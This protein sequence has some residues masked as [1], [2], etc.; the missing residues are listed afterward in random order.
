M[1]ATDVGTLFLD[2]QLRIKRFTPKVSELFNIQAP[3]EGRP[4]TD[5]THRLDYP[6]FAAD[7][8][9]VLKDLK[10]IER[11]IESNGSWFLTRIRPY[12]TVDDRIEGVVCTFVDITARL[13][14]EADL[15]ASEA[16]L[17]LLLSE[18][19][20]RVKNTLAVVQAMARLSFAE[21]VPRDQARGGVHEQA[22]RTFRRP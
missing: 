7:A 17:R 10:I 9:A 14:M 6:N 21:D 19:S 20:H 5:F 13:K 1:A 16:H 12:R 2:H 18:L 11:E 8:N 3:D 15:K 22:Y 4:I